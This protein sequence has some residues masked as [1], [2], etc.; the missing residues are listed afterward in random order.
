MILFVIWIDGNSFWA[1][2]STG[3]SMPVLGR[4]FFFPEF[5][6]S[7]TFTKCNLRPNNR[8]EYCI[9]MEWL[10]NKFGLRRIMMICSVL[11]SHQKQFLKRSPKSRRTVRQTNWSKPSAA[12]GASMAHV[13]LWHQSRGLGILDKIATML[14]KKTNNIEDMVFY[15]REDLVVRH[16]E[17]RPHVYPRNWNYLRHIVYACIFSRHRHQCRFPQIHA[18][19]KCPHCNHRGCTLVWYKRQEY[20]KGSNYWRKALGACTIFLILRVTRHVCRVN[21]LLHMRSH[22]TSAIRSDS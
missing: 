9:W 12:I 16:S 8:L 14:S 11:T 7:F 18:S 10:A 22:V 5:L 4:S 3:S 17:L 1:D 2:L 15:Q 19:Q 21:A 20:P 6:W 13:H